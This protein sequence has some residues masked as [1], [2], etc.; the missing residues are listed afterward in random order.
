MHQKL[1][2]VLLGAVLMA[3]CGSVPP[4]T[5]SS[6]ATPGATPPSEPTDGPPSD[7]P[8]AL[9]MFT[10]WSDMLEAVRRSPD[11][12]AARADAL[13]AAGDAQAIFAFVRDEIL[14]Y[15]PDPHS[16]A[17]GTDSRIRWGT[18]ATLRGGAGTPRER[19]ELLAEL[20]HRSG[21]EAQV[22]SGISTF[23]E[24]DVERALNRQVQRS[25]DPPLDRDLLDS[26]LVAAG[27]EPTSVDGPLDP[28]GTLSRALGAQL[29][30]LLPD[31]LSARPPDLTPSVHPW[32][33]VVIGGVPTPADPLLVDAE[34]GRAYASTSSPAPSP[35]AALPVHLEV[36][37]SS[38]ARPEQAETVLRADWPAEDVVG[39][40]LVLRFV[41]AGDPQAVLTSAPRDLQVFT[42]VVVVQAVDQPGYVLEGSSAFGTAITVGGETL[43][44]GDGT[45]VLAG[46]S[47]GSQPENAE[48]AR[49]VT[50]VMVEPDVA[51]FPFVQLDVTPLDGSG[52]LVDG[53][54]VSAFEVV[55]DGVLQHPLMVGDRLAP[56]RIQLIF[57]NSSSMPAD[58]VDEARVSFALSLVSDIQAQTPGTEFQ[59]LGL[60]AV[61]PW[62]A[63]Q[64]VLHEQARSVGFASSSN[65]WATLA[66]AARAQGDL[67]ILVSDWQAGDELTDAIRSVIAGG[68]A[69]LAVNVADTAGDSTMELAAEITGG[70]GLRA[71]SATEVAQAALS[72]VAEQ[73]LTRPAYRLRYRAPADGPATRQISVRM[74]V[75]ELGANTS[76]FAVVAQST[77]LVPSAE[78]HGLPIGIGQIQ[79]TLS[80]G[81]D[82]VTRTIAGPRTPPPG[83]PLAPFDP[84]ESWAALF[85]TV[86]ISLEGAAPT[87]AAVL[88]DLLTANLALQPL[89]AALTNDDHIAVREALTAG[90]PALP[91]ALMN[92]Q[93]ALPGAGAGESLTFE[94]GLRAVLFRAQPMAHGGYIRAVDILPVTRWL[95]ADR[96]PRRSLEA[97]VR[98]TAHLAVI[99]GALFPRSTTAVLDQAAL[100]Y[101]GPY[102]P[103]DLGL[104]FD[105]P[106]REARLRLDDLAYRF[107]GRLVA[108]DSLRPAYWAIDPGG[109]TLWGVLD[110]GSGGGSET[111]DYGQELASA[112]TVFSTLGLGG[113]LLLAGPAGL[114]F[115]AILVLGLAAARQY[116]RAASLL[117]A[118]PGG[119]PTTNDQEIKNALCNAARAG[120]KYAY[121]ETGELASRLNQLE[122]F[123]DA[124][125]A[126]PF[127]C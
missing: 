70:R 104:A 116:I 53:L 56:P 113:D 120:A 62:S 123:G 78:D 16:F 25:F 89:A 13:V 100:T 93:A 77:Y 33:E 18:R 26:R 83:M 79:L 41:P 51:A 63:D 17:A 59:V 22:V 74:A 107:A 24:A 9:P 1:S 117:N 119:P 8:D 32:V 91:A 97:T 71:G 94:R 98:R 14:V 82:S 87:A 5:S 15:P 55:E 96:D 90:W 127:S 105:D 111:E 52:D 36:T 34:F 29:A 114:A 106:E 115:G 109:G 73:Q 80:V 86:M 43:A 67:V 45:L 54:P 20:Y 28:G 42:P 37:V 31:E 49:L 121:A 40:Q 112:N 126:S 35:S 85:G 6:T 99:E 4:P 101:V 124:T 19:A 81:D 47:F 76:Y 102:V 58:F 125:S 84:D 48:G 61:A 72:W 3:G 50:R 108:T 11:H 75:S 118:E 23:T 46:R 12:L 95:T 10:L 103:A 30:G 27:V 57:D 39:R 60:E 122:S 64:A 68:P 21:F 7:A 88:D 69:V 2:V 65:L 66:G 38:A 110:D 92:L 44:A